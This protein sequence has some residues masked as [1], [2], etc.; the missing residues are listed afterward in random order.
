MDFFKNANPK[1][2]HAVA[3]KS[4]QIKTSVVSVPPNRYAQAKRKKK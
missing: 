1:G 3:A 4:Q 2:S